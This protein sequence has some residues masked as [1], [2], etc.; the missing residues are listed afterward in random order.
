MASYEDALLGRV[1]PR[2][3]AVRLDRLTPKHIEDLYKALLA[4]GG[5][6]ERRRTGLSERTVSYTGK[7]LVH[8]VGRRRQA[9]IRLPKSCK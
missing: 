7:V 4:T 8:H 9:R 5:H 1:V 3:G 2:I 6:D